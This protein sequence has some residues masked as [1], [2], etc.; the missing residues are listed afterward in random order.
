ML[1]CFF[2]GFTLLFLKFAE[3]YFKQ[4]VNRDTQVKSEV[5]LLIESPVLMTG[6]M[7][8]DAQ[9]RIGGNFNE[10]YVS[11]ELTGSGAQ[12]FA[13]LTEKYEKRRMAIILDGKVRSAP[14]ITE[15]IAGGSV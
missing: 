5:P 14:V 10:P 12:T 7:V 13:Q 6:A 9:V 11:L 3:V 15:K 8:K 4:V 2:M 1:P